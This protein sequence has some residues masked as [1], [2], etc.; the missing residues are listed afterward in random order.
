M[1]ELGDREKQRHRKEMRVERQ[2]ISS[3]RKSE[4]R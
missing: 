3:D 4:V 1:K 2:E